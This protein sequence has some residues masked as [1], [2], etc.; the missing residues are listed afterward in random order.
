MHGCMLV[1]GLKQE[2]HEASGFARPCIVGLFFPCWKIC[3]WKAA[4]KCK[5]NYVKI[6]WIPAGDVT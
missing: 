5:Y 2:A 1:T 4:A 3:E 6:N